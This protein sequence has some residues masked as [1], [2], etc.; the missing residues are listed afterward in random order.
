MPYIKVQPLTKGVET[1]YFP[2]GSFQIPQKPSG[3]STTRV[4]KDNM[5]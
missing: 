2:S 4:L 3:L 1:Y 5:L